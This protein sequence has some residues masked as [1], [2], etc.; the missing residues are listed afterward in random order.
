[1]RWTELRKTSLAVATAL[2]LSGAISTAS[3]AADD[4]LVRFGARVSWIAAETM[5][6]STDD[7]LPVSV[8]L[9]QVPQDEYQRLAT[10]ARVIVIGTLG[11][12][13]VLATSIELLEP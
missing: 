11:G 3:S 6:V 12:R 2:A 8:D 7:G 13:R 1:M 5:V 9:A 10:G 4:A